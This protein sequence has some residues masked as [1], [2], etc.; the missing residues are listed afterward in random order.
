M[1]NKKIILILIGISSLVMG[2]LNFEYDNFIFISYITVSL[3][4]FIGLWEDIKNIW[5]HKSA[6]IIVSGI[7]SVLIGIYELLKYLFEW[8]AIYTSDGDIPEFKVYIYV[9]TFLMLYIFIRET[10][11]LKK[12]GEDK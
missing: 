5:Y 3:I 9:F 7:I 10:N 12:T 4:A 11:Y 6:H 1:I 2:V 8:L